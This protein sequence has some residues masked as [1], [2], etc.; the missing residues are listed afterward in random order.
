MTPCTRLL[1]RLSTLWTRSSQLSRSTSR[2]RSESTKS[3]RLISRISWLTTTRSRVQ[4]GKLAQ[5]SCTVKPYLSKE[6]S[7]C[8]QLTTM[9]SSTTSLPGISSSSHSIR[10]ITQEALSMLQKETRV[11]LLAQKIVSLLISNS[12]D[13]LA[14]FC[15]SRTTLP[16]QGTSK[17][18]MRIQSCALLLLQRI[19][20]KMV[21]IR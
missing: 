1:S 3:S 12:M 15:S 20:L 18:N 7:I 17:K 5:N 11:W 13:K 10:D 16:S 4:R 14:T 2:L 19:R 21:C 6:K 8:G 9:G